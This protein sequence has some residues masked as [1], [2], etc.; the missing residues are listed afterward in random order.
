MIALNIFWNAQNINIY[1]Q[2]LHKFIHTQKLKQKKNKGALCA[3]P[4]T[5]LPFIKNV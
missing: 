1:T 4:A 5:P 3:A 2:T